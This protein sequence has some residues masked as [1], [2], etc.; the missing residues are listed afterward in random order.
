MSWRCVVLA[1][2]AVTACASRGAAPASAPS[3]SRPAPAPVAAPAS[4]A[5]P[6]AAE[7]RPSTE[8]GR[9]HPSPGIECVPPR[10]NSP[11]E[12]ARKLVSAGEL[13]AAADCLVLAFESAPAVPRFAFDA[14][15]LYR[16]AERLD[17]ARFYY[18]RFIV[19]APADPRVEEARR[20]LRELGP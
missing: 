10:L 13:S 12:E 7:C 18:E 4:S 19:A 8:P 6:R 3:P 14:A 20:A 2:V 15:R 1:C 11:A 17:L 5:Y 9:S 16:M